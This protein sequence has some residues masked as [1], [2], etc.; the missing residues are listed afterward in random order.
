MIEHKY[1]SMNFSFLVKKKS[2]VKKKKKKPRI[3]WNEIDF[4]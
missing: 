2:K 4:L 3:V 1:P